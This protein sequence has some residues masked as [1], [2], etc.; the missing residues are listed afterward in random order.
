[1]QKEKIK[2]PIWRHKY[3]EKEKVSEYL[4]NQLR[5]DWSSGTM[6]VAKYNQRLWAFVED[7]KKM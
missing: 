7:I 3:V 5:E 1:M 6:S 2:I 4:L